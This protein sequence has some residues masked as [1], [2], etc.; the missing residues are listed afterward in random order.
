MQCPKSQKVVFLSKNKAEAA[1][2]SLQL[3]NDYTGHIYPCV[4]CCGYHIGRDKKNAH[5]NKY[6][7]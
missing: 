6:K 1:L 7:K 3:R 2:K 4:D 5:K